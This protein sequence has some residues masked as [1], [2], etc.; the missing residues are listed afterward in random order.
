[1]MLFV[2]L[3]LVAHMAGVSSDM[4]AKGA[5]LYVVARAI[6]PLT[7]WTGIPYARTLVW[8]AGVIGTIMVFLP[9]AGELLFNLASSMV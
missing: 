5:M 3:A 1:M 9:V 8:T 2:P 6:Y 7:Y 4:L